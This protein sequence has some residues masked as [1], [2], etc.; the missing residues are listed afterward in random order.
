[1]KGTPFKTRRISPFMQADPGLGGGQI[2]ID[3]NAGEGSGDAKVGRV[4]Q[5]DIDYEAG[6]DFEAVASFLP[7]TG[8]VIDAKNAIKD[9]INEDYYGA[10]LNLAG[11]AIPFVPG[12]VVKG[13]VKKIMEFIRRQPGAE[14]AI[15]KGEDLMGSGSK[16]AGQMSVRNPGAPTG[17]NPATGYKYDM[18]ILDTDNPIPSFS[19]ANMEKV[20]MPRMKKLGQTLDANN[21]DVSALT[22]DNITFKG[23]SGGRTIVEV[24]LGNGQKQ[25]FY[26]STGSAE[27]VGSGIGGTTEGLWQ[28]YAGH[29]NDAADFGRFGKDA[30]YEDWYG[31]ESFKEISGSLDKLAT[32]KGINLNLQMDYSVDKTFETYRKRVG[33]DQADLSIIQE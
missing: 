21:F 6:D 12:S 9:L 10:A 16:T 28:P 30:G 19:K 31:S 20:E 11:F 4:K 1:M 17:V 14:E 15:K 25:L 13:G 5:S 2:P 29:S 26:K 27:K 3:P 24:D 33:V 7:G 23:R 32:E 18:D 22:A 8:E